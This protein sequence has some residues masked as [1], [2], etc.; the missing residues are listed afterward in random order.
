MENTLQSVRD[1]AQPAALLDGTVAAVMTPGIRSC[2]PETPLT[3]VAEIMATNHVHAVAVG[4]VAEDH[5]VWGVIDALG[6]VRALRTPAA[7]PTARSISRRPA[8]SIEPE[9][10][11]ADAARLMDEGG[12]GHLV[13]VDRERPVGIISTLDIARAA[14]RTHT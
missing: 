14:A 8:T 3:R 10:Q 4:G 6:L 12:L 7:H 9:A 5:L 13:V 1:A 11:L 2:A